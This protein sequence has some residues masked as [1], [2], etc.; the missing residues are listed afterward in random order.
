MAQELPYFRFTVQQWQNGNISLERYE[1]QGLF[2]SICGYYWLQD[3]NATLAM[4]QK[5]FSNATILLNELIELRILKHENKHDKIQIDFL[6]K[7]YDL[8]SEKRKHRQIAGSKGG[9][10]KAMLKQKRSYKDKDKDK[11]NILPK[12]LNKINFSESEIFDKIK[13]AKAFPD[14]SKDK[15]K[16]YYEAADR[17]S[18]EG[19][20]YVNWDR[21]VHNW[22]TKDE[23]QGKIKFTVNNNSKIPSAIV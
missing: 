18:N 8:L 23:V 21:A 20:K 22:A 10:A 2:I 19:N 15:L 6:N 7:Q 14:W 16:Y 9:N 4:L 3:C 17:Y 12:K 11:D 5:K 1:L 13:F